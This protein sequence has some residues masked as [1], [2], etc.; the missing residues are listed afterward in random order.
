MLLAV[1]RVVTTPA[2]PISTWLV[3]FGT[4]AAAYVA[5]QGYRYTKRSERQKKVD[6]DRA[7]EMLRYKADLEQ[8]ET[9]KGIH[10]ALWGHTEGT[11]AIPGLV[12]VVVGKNGE[13]TVRDVAAA[14]LDKIA[15]VEDRQIVV[16]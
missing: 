15:V 9:I 3:T 7:A 5:Y 14:A 10:A 13:G 16:S 1:T 8:E 11:T 12:R 4:I 2:T 6:E